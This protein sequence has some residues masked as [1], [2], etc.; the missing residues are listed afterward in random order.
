[1]PGRLTTAR[2]RFALGFLAALSFA[3]V[4]AEVFLRCSPPEDLFP[5]LGD[6]SP[7]TGHLVPGDDFGVRFASLADLIADNP[8]TLGLDSPLLAGNASTKS[9][10]FIGNSFGF[11]LCGRL[12]ATR[13]DITGL[14]LDRREKLH[15]RMAQMAVLAEAGVRIERAYLVITPVDFKFLGE[16]GLARH[17]ANAGGAAVFTPR[18]PSAPFADVVD[19]SRLALTAWVRTGWHQ[20]DSQFRTRH[21][22][23]RVVPH[24]KA[25]IDRLFANLAR[26]T[27]NHDFP[28]TVV[29]VP[30]K[31]E[32]VPGA[33]FAIEDVLVEAARQRGLDLVDPRPEF[34][35]HPRKNDLYIADGHLTAEGDDI[36][37][38][39]LERRPRATLNVQPVSRPGDDK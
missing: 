37:L 14:V 31:T 33:D 16:H 24:L 21:L 38:A 35:S 23:R 7:L 30:M 13:T 10:L 36:V 26:I 1:M 28:I 12:L 20:G 17:T 25:D 8:R 18:L 27:R 4:A 5:Y 2:V 32:V 9:R 34:L 19:N 39:A 22:S 6:A 3:G 29:L 15:V 11:N